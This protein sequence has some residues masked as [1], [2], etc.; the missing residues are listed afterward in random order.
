MPRI[1]VRW[2]LKDCALA[3]TVLCFTVRR[4]NHSV[5]RGRVGSGAHNLTFR[6]VWSV[7][8]VP[9]QDECS[10]TRLIGWAV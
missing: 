6:S 7:M 9:D 4:A 5:R 3:T 10:R 2:D 1:V 8:A